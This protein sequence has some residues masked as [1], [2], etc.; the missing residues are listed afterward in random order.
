[1]QETW[2]KSLG[3]EDPLEEAMTTHS[4]ILARKTPWT[5]EPGGLQ[6]M[7]SQRV[8]HNWTTEHACH[9]N[10]MLY[11]IPRVT[12]PWRR[13]WQLTTVLLP[14]ESHAQRS[15]AGY[16]PWGHKELDTAEQ[17]ILTHRVTTRKIPVEN[18]PKK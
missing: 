10:K 8:R 17:L 3:W 7:G 18:A 4:S 2:V 16:S 5:E 14:G 13:E 9:D 11:V 1:M 6:S 15:R 12:A